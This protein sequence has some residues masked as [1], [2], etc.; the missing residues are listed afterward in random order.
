MSGLSVK[1]G[2]AWGIGRKFRIADFEMRIYKSTGH[3]S[4]PLEV[5]GA[6]RLRLEAEGKIVDL[7][8]RRL[9]KFVEVA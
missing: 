3:G 2:E 1:D 8:I 4:M 5:G 6:L 7:R 9:V